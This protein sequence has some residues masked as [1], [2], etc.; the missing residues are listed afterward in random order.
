MRAVVRGR[1]RCWE[2][3]GETQAE[4]RQETGEN[5]REGQANNVKN[6][7]PQKGKRKIESMKGR[8]TPREAKWRETGR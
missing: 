4:E 8:E 7:R 2:A 5:Q 3:E 1:G 6:V